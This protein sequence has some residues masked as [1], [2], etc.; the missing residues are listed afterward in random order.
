M[1]KFNF[2]IDANSHLLHTYNPACVICR[3]A[4]Q[5]VVWPTDWQSRKAA[6]SVILKK[7]VPQSLCK[8]LSMSPAQ[9]H[10]T[11]QHTYII[12]RLINH[13]AVTKVAMHVQYRLPAPREK[14]PSLTKV[15]NLTGSQ[16]WG[17]YKPSCCHCTRKREIMCVYMCVCSL[18]CSLV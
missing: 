2:C 8:T 11:S 14:L 3:T 18:C 15:P 12:Q 17:D 6:H 10:I 7:R 5:L 4:Q 9:V 16:Q 13:L 1:L